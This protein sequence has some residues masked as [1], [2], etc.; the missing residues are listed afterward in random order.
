[1]KNTIEELDRAM[2][3]QLTKSEALHDQYLYV[4]SMRSE[5]LKGA[6]S[7][8]QCIRTELKEVVNYSSVSTRTV[9]VSLSISE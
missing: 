3:Q 1:M 4:L 5:W 7:L 2:D 9:S 8:E 6:L